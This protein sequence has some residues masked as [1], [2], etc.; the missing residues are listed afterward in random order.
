MWALLVIGA[1]LTY[2]FGC[3]VKDVRQGWAI[4]AVM[5]ILMLAGVTVLYA[6]EGQGNVAVAAAHVVQPTGNMEG[7][8]VRF[9]VAMLRL[10]HHHIALAFSCIKHRY[11]G[12]H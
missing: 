5:S 12:E 3:M 8:E 9:G 7:K 11:S 1:S 6:A 2:T 4:F 10:R